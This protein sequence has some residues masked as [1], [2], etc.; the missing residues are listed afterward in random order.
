MVFSSIISSPRGTLSPQQALKLA[1]VYL[2]NACK[3]ND[4]DITMV[5]CHDT[6]IS[7]SQAKKAVKRTEDQYVI[8]EIAIAYMDLGDL[9]KSR[10]HPNEANVSYKKAGKLGVNVQGLGRQRVTGRP[11]STTSS[12]TSPSGAPQALVQAHVTTMDKHKQR[13]SIATIPSHIFAKNVRPPAIEYKLPGSDERLTN[14]PQLAYCLYLLKPDRSP[15]DTLDPA[16]HNWL[17]TT[18]KDVDEQERLKSMATELIKAFKRDELKDA[19]TVAEVVY[20]V[21]VLDKDSFQALLSIFYSGIDPSKLLKVHHLEGLAQSIQSADQG[22]LNADDLV[23]ILGLLNTRLRDTHQQSSDHMYQLTLAISHVLDAMADTKVTGLDREKLH[24]PLS[25]YLKELKESE[26]PYLVYQ[27]AYAFQALLWVPD[28]ETTWQAAMRHTGKVIQGVSGVVSAMRGLDLN[29]FIEGLDDIQK[30]F[31]GAF[32]AVKI[33]KNSYDGVTS[34]AQSGQGLLETLKEGFS[35]E[36]KRDWYSALRGADTLIREGELATFKELVC[37]APCQLDPAFQWGVCQR[38]GKIA[39][40]PMWD[41]DTRRGAIEFLGEIYKNDEVWGQHASVKQ[42]ILNILMQLATASETGPQYAGA[43]LREL[44]STGD[45]RKQAMY[46]SC[47]EKGPISYPLKVTQPELASPSLLDHVQNRPDVEGNIRLLRKQRTKARGNVVYIPPQG[48]TSVQAADD[49]RFPLMEKIKEFLESDKKVF[50]LMGD[51]GAGKS[52]FNRELEF[53]LWQSYENRTGRI[54]LHINLPAIDKPEHDMIA[55]QLRMADFTESQIREMKNHRK[56]VLICDGYDESQQTHNLY[57]SN[58]LNQEGEWDA[59]M[60]ISCRTEYLGTD[61]RDR[62]QPGDRNHQSDSSLFQE[63]VITL[64]SLDQVQDYIRQYVIVHR[65][66]WEVEEYKQAL[67]RIPSLKELVRNPFLMTL[68][69]EV[70]PRMVDPGQRLSEA[71]VTRVGLYDHFV[72]QWLERGKKRLREKDLNIQAKAAFESLSDEGF[73]QHGMEFMKK[74]AVS[75]YKEQDG[76]PIVRYSR[77]KGEQS[78]KSEFFSR[79][80]E[81][82]L[83]R[84]ACPLTRNG[85]QHRFIHRSL[86]EYALARAIFDPQDVE[87][88]SVPETVMRRRGSSSS[89]LSFEVKNVEKRQ[90]EQGPDLDSPLVWRS[91]VNDHSLLRLLEERVQQEPVFKSQLLDY[92]EHSKKDKKWRQAAANAITIL[93]RS[94]EQFNG[95]DLKGIQ[96]PGADLSYGVFDSAQLQNADLRK[97]NLRGVWLRQADLRGAQMTGVQ[98]GEL[99][100]LKVD[101]TRSCAYSPDGSSIAVGLDDGSISVYSTSNWERTLTLE[102]HIDVVKRVVFSP[103]GDKIASASADKTIRLWDVETGSQLQVLKIHASEVCG[104]AYSPHGNMIASGAVDKTV[105]LWDVVAGGCRKVLSGHTGIVYGVAYSPSGDRVASCSDDHMIRLW[106]VETGEC[107]RTP[108]DHSAAVRDVTYSPHGDQVAS[109][110]QDSAVRLWNVETGS[111][112][113]I[114]RGHTR[115]VLSV[116]YSPKGDQVV[117]GSM[118]T[119]VRF[120]DV[121][122]GSCRHTLTGHSGSVFSVSYSPKGDKVVTGSPDYTLR[123]WDTSAGSSRLVSNGH[124][125]AV[126]SIKCSPKGDLIVSGSADNTIRL[127]DVKTGACRTLSGPTGTVYCVAFSPKGDWIASGSDNYYESVLLWKVDSGEC[128]HILSSHAGRVNSVAFSPSGDTVAS[129]S[130]DETV[131]LWDVATGACRQTLRGHTQGVLSVVYAP[132]GKQIATGSM[133]R[134]IRLWDA[135]TGECCKKLG[136]SGYV[137][138]VVYLPEGDQLIS[139]CDDSTIRLWDVQT[140]KRGRIIGYTGWTAAYSANVKLLA[141]VSSDKT[142]LWDASSGECRAVVGNFPDTIDCISW[143]TSSDPNYLVTGCKDGS[144]LKWQVLKEDQYRVQLQWS[145]SNGSLAVRGASIQGACG[146]TSLNKQLLLQRG[147]IGEPEHLLRETSEKPTTMASVVSKLKET[148]EDIAESSSSSPLQQTWKASV[149]ELTTTIAHKAATG[150]VASMVIFCCLVLFLK[151]IAK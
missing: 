23:K 143:S 135:D 137:R 58:K 123:L 47:Q 37:L 26:D 51:S 82:R 149:A 59:Q 39:M 107:I 83:L 57:M 48:K 61:Y 35:F 49:T 85:N 104:L 148:S 24:E 9:L 92:I 31:E 46:R 54:P 40:N 127:W 87:R 117:S 43:L 102:R 94:G 70:L 29:K 93:V 53:T 150:R 79:D 71:R 111:C 69:L 16:A 99:P 100:Y 108:L 62:F 74:L 38:L 27:A 106:D 12:S 122:T 2:D 146:L 144:V 75:I 131:K 32:K 147:A 124:S 97:V 64:F 50:L 116:V 142:V 77:A 25:T 136:L 33:I 30:G 84:E 14:T 88:V 151:I 138:E 134:T 89:T 119:T 73:T 4:G 86:L 11:N 15:D 132:D 95:T 120:W 66:L 65:P 76:H 114:L 118:D 56:F 105:R 115:D 67:E 121:E 81:K 140:E 28:D 7:L 52:T 129:A 78:W 126:R 145:A 109:A 139:V 130:E 112:L 60:V 125:A 133:D 17:N 101:S 113:H 3:E 45:D 1:N 96:I 5:L 21:P 41:A 72:A 55:K 63:A 90:P 44:E 18:K 42:W 10:G 98:F 6:E 91:F 80:K 13:R 22:H 34:L 36:R 103:T 20:L 68:S 19:K 141:S 8:E 110:S 128:Q